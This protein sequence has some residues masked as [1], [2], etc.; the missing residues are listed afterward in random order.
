MRLSVAIDATMRTVIAAT[1]QLETC[2]RI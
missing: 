2:E 1:A